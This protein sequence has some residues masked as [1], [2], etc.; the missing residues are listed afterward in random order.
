MKVALVHDYL[1]DAGGAERVLEV[2]HGLY[3]EAPIYTSI[4]DPKTTF[5]CFNEMNVHTSFLQ[6]ITKSKRHYKWLLPLYS[7]AFE[8][9]NFSDY[10]V[11]LS[12]SSAWAKGVITPPNVCHISYCYSPMRFAWSFNEYIERENFPKFLKRI[13]PLVVA[14]LKRWDLISSKRVDYFIANS[15]LTADR[16]EKIYKRKATVIYP[17]V[18]CSEF[19]VNDSSKKDSFLIVSR[20]VP[21]KRIDLA[22][23]A[24]TKL[25]LPLVIIGEGR[26]RARL[27]ALAGPTVHFLGRA[28]D[29]DRA[30]YMSHCRAFL[31]PGR[32]DFGI[33]P[34]QAQ[35]A[36]RPVIAYAAGGAL[37]TVIEG[38]TG[39][40]FHQPAEEALIE[41]LLHFDQRDYDP[42]IIRR[43]AERFDTAVF[44]R[45]LRQLIPQVLAKRADDH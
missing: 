6:Y 30:R 10:D 40:L 38:E 29:A 27:E 31:F 4:F 3:P 43:N 8:K 13:L 28:S 11:V 18:R 20:I 33:A 34:V 37:D 16:I 12:S 41:A 9:F 19:I 24:C 42:V 36:G 5:S 23:Q 32:E 22:V 7:L 35:A 44:R 39:T 26:D 17:P 25:S 14:P 21:Y 45:K 2:F 1:V 15:R